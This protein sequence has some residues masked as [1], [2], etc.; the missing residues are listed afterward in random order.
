MRVAPGQPC[1]ARSQILAIEGQARHAALSDQTAAIEHQ[2]IVIGLDLIEQVSGPEH[3]HALVTAERS[4]MLVECLAAGRVE[5]CTGLVEQQQLGVMQ[6]RAGD[7]DASAVTAV[8]FTHLAAAPFAELLALQL[9]FDAFIR[10]GPRHAVQGGV[11]AQV[12]LDSQVQVQ[13][14][15]LEHHAE[16]GERLARRL[17]QAE[18]GDADLPRC[19]SYR[20]VSRAINVDLPAPF[21]PSSA[22]NLPLAAAK[23]TPSSARRA[24]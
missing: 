9:E 19:R 1:K 5:A 24:P 10:Q 11:V 17:A 15:L 12:L 13:R 20:R 3:A 22:V 18:A 23:L 16:A 7:L 14:A 21:G 6:Q 8:E 2:Q 4:H